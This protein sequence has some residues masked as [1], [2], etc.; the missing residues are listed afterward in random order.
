[1]GAALIIVLEVVYLVP[2]IVA[3]TRGITRIGPCFVVNI[4]LGWTL[5]GWVVAFVLAL[6]GE[7]ETTRATK[8]VDQIA[9]VARGVELALAAERTHPLR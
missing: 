9:A 1:M 7:T 4:F 6:T 8:Q 5:V 2:I 3:Q